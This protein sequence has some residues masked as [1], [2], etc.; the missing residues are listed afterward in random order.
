MATGDRGS[1]VRGKR[2]HF[3]SKEFDLVC[4]QDVSFER[5][6]GLGHWVNI[7]SDSDS[8]SDILKVGYELEFQ[9]LE[10]EVFY[11]LGHGDRRQ[12]RGIPKKAQGKR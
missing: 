10:V 12:V 7:R 5:E 6:Q 11:M 4:S 8:Q 3:L 1:S 2:L 9:L